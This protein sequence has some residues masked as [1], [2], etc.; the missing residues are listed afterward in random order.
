MYT[1]D[2]STKLEECLDTQN[3]QRTNHSIKNINEINMGWE[4]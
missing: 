1:H 2:L 4:T 3:N